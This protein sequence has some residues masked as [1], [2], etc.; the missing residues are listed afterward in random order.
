MK[1]LTEISERDELLDVGR[2]AVEDRL[3]E[4]RELRIGILDRGNG[5]VIKE[6]NGSNSHVIR[7]GTE[8][9][10]RIGLRAIAVHLEEQD[11]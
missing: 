8:Q 1:T 5:L 9:A 10:L 3:V 7:M 2:K 6:S 11:A 4:L